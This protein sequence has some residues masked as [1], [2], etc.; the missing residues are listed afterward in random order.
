[1]ISK[2]GTGNY[3][4]NAS[5]RYTGGVAN[6]YQWL[7]LFPVSGLNRETPRVTFVPGDLPPG[8]YDAIITVDGGPVAGSAQIAVTLRLSSQAPLPVLTSAVNPASMKA[9]S[10]AVPG[11]AFTILGDRLA[12][13]KVAVTFDGI[14]AQVLGAASTNRIDVLVPDEVAGSTTSLVKVNVDGLLSNPGLTVPIAVAAPVIV[15]GSIVNADATTNSPQNGALGGTTIQF[16][17]NGLPATGVFTGQIHDR[18]IDGANLIYAGPAPS[19]PGFQLVIMNVPPDLP[20]MTTSVLV[21]GGA[22]VDAMVCS[23]AMDITLIAVPPIPDP[24]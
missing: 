1:V 3:L 8:V 4:W 15:P 22:S 5:V 21:C 6:G 10:A 2:S 9:G 12:G 11:S 23:E 18:I 19:M 24:Q 20:S 17:T 16:I 14:A 7:R 13:S